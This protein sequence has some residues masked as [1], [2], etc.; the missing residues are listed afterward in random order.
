MVAYSGGVDSSFLLKIA[1]DCLKDKVLAVT[2]ISETYTKEELKFAKSFCRKFGIRHKII[3]TREL[4]NKKF[5][6]N[7]R[8][9]CYFCKKELFGRLK[10][11]AQKS[12]VENIIDA[13]NSDDKNDFRP[14]EKAKSEFGV[15]SPLDEAGITKKDIRYLS[16]RLNLPSWDRP[17]MACLASRMQYGTEITGQRL[18]RVEKAE[19]ILRKKFHIK[20][21]IRVRD[22]MNSARIEVDKPYL[23]LLTNMNGFVLK[24][25]RLGYNHISVD[26]EGYRTGSM[27]QE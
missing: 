5:I 21:N 16:R 27:N 10:G 3:K 24:L 2:A 17:Q 11:I 1:K 9:R 23:P 13:T 7:T 4:E 6:A 12:A 15:R 26:L 20:G 14:G 8:E 22:Y 19:E 25:K 18:R